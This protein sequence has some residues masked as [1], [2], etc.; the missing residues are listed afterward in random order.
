MKALRLVIGL[1]LVPGCLAVSRTLYF[2]V[3]SL[4][5]GEPDA[6]MSLWLASGAGLWAWMAVF[7]FLPAPVKSYVLAHELSHV[8]WGCLMGASLLG[9]KISKKGGTVKL[10]EINFLVVLAPYFFP[11]YT[12]IIICAYFLGSVFADL[13]RYELLFYAL[14][15]FTLG[16][17]VFFTVS[18][19]SQKQPDIENYGKTFSYP[20]IYFANAMVIGLLLVVVAPLSMSQFCGRLAIDFVFVWSSIWQALLKALNYRQ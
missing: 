12:M 6:V 19:L 14:V 5:A 16:Y 7:V 13:H 18:A 10:S 11:L 4:N 17:H 8:L 1:F 2:V 15:G 9:I 20:L 3:L